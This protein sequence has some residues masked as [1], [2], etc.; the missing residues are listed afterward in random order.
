MREV[1]LA[2]IGAGPAG[3]SAAL[4]AKE[5]G[6]SVTVV[7]ENPRPGG[8]IFRQLPETFQVLRP[9]ALGHT[10]QKGQALLN[11]VA[12]A[13]IDLRTDTLVWGIF[14]PLTLALHQGESAE[15][16]RCR[17][18]IL[19]TGAYDRLIPFPG[20]TLPGV[21]TLGGAQTL[22]KSQRILP[23]K[24]VLLAGS[25]PFLLPVAA[26]LL[27]GGANIVAILEASNPRTWLRKSRALWGQWERFREA[28]EYLKPLIS[29]RPRVRF[30]QTIVAARGDDVLREV[31]IASLDKN[32][33][34]IGDSEYS[35]EVDAACVGF[36][37]TINTQLSRPC[38]CKHVYRPWAGGWVVWH[39]GWQRTSVPNVFVAGESTGVAGVDTAM[40]EGAIAGLGAAISLGAISESEAELR[41]RAHRKRLARLKPFVEMQGELFSHREGLMELIT[42][43]TIVCRCEEV[44][45]GEILRALDDGA[46]DVNGVKSRVRTGMGLC[47]GRVC[48]PI[49]A[50]MVARRTGQPVEE[51]GVFTA[52]PIVKPVPLAAIAAMD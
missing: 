36:G 19:A 27:Q 13:G 25:G 46:T 40:G 23:G 21:M 43:E 50:E 26:Q 42:D 15:S 45:A 16:L 34:P 1:D 8:Q 6:V 38:E 39:D 28:I 22:A 48:G 11:R 32:W 9:G 10:F 29:S 5:A 7:D 3:L 51:S 47:Q 52:R 18:L 31:T 37:F 33:S 12:Q 4:A 14:H 24:R 17:A 30:G 35:L 41:A 20:W 2:I 44:T 49:V